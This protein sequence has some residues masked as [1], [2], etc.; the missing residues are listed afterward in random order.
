[1][2]KKTQTN[3]IHP[4][5]LFKQRPSFCIFCNA[6]KTILTLINSLQCVQN[7]FLLNTYDTNIMNVMA[8]ES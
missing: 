3:S 7:I 5:V 8:P 6:G 4:Q 1:M 2:P